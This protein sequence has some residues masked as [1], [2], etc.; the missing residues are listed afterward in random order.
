M[1]FSYAVKYKGVYYPPNT[2]IAEETPAPE[3]DCQA[4]ADKPKPR[5]RKVK[6]D[7]D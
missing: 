6:K 2:E 5:T 4:C 1:K 3:V 7:D